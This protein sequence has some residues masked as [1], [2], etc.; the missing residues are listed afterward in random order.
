M[1]K[2]KPIIVKNIKSISQSKLV[3]TYYD[4]LVDLFLLQNPQCRFNKNYHQPLAE[5]IRR[6]SK[7]NWLYFPW[8]DKYV[9]VLPEKDFLT[10]RTGRNREIITQVEQKK[11]YDC[12]VGVAGL[13][14]GSHAAISIAVMGGSKF[15]K[16]ADLDILSPS[17]LNRVRYT[18]FD[19]GKS[20]CTLASQQ[21]YQIN[22]YANIKIFSQGITDKNLYNFLAGP[23]KLDVLIEEMDNLEMKIKIRLAAR[24][25]GIPVIMATDNA[26]N[27]LVDVERYDQNRNLKIFNGRIGNFT[28]SDFKKIKPSELPRLSTKI[29]GQDKVAPRMQRSLLGVGKTI[30]SWPQLGDAAML[31]GVSIAYLVR[32]LANHQPLKSGQYEINF[33]E[34]FDPTYHQPNKIRYRKKELDNFLNIIGL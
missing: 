31:S 5:F 22:P 10:V 4:Q 2:E 32:R 20:K 19:I 25:L 1:D 26:D 16:L 7:G 17:N 12:K 18:L 28:I 13:S 6:A 34:I 24:K 14:V 9:H 15:M 30:Y 11:F 3:D 8:L 27:I 21:I 23:P 29:A 33:D